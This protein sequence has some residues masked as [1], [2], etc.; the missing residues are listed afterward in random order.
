[1]IKCK[2]IEYNLSDVVKWTVSYPK[3]YMKKKLI[4]VPIILSVKHVK[5][6][7]WHAQLMC[8]CIMKIE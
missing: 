8:T 6:V 2:S 1:M 7:L 4:H 5:N 3:K